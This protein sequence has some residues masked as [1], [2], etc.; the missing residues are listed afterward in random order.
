MYTSLKLVIKLKCVTQF[1]VHIFMLRCA[2]R[3]EK[4]ACYSSSAA[5]GKSEMKC[6]WVC[7]RE[8]TKAASASKPQ[9]YSSFSQFQYEI[10]CES[11]IA[12]YNEFSSSADFFRFGFGFALCCHWREYFVVVVCAAL[13]FSGLTMWHIDSFQWVLHF[14]WMVI[15]L[16]F[17]NS[18]SHS[19]PRHW[20]T[21][22]KHSNNQ[23]V[24][25]TS[26]VAATAAANKLRNCLK[27]ILYRFL[28]DCVGY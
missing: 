5:A 27:F 24:L 9:L 7:V 1:H 3:R 11:L 13:V 21:R 25:T 15:C 8:G 28:H 12:F 19:H 10:V 18:I 20:F 2:S 23:P 26:A 6:V 16:F 14:N 17:H 22:L 4:R